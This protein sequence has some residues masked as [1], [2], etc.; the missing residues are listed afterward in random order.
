LFVGFLALLTSGP[1]V[2][3]Q[4]DHANPVELNRTEAPQFELINPPVEQ[5]IIPHRLT[6]FPRPSPSPGNPV[7]FPTI[8]RAAGTIFSGTVAAVSRRTAPGGQTIE[9]ISVT[10]HVEQ[11]IRGATPGENLTIAQWMGLWSSGQRYRVG[12][13]LMVFLYPASK[14]GLT[15]L[16][17][18]G[19]GRFVV[20]P[21]GRVLLNAQHMN[22][23]RKDAVLGGKSRVRVSDF[24][25]AVS[26]AGE[27]DSEP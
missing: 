10:F 14:L 22:A 20:D 18:G 15:S 5:P 7:G 9:T 1:L 4:S 8:A 23:F 2:H 3:S 17:G 24:V 21:Y 12:E 19:L 25:L 13:H 11:A 6:P 16:V 27:E 26:R